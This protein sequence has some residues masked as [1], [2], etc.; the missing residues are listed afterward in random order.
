MEAVELL[1]D[2]AAPRDA[3]DVRRA[4]RDRFDQRRQ[5]AGVL[6]Q[7]EL[8]GHVGRPARAGLIPGDDR[9]L[10]R[11]CGDLRP[12]QAAVRGGT[13]H[14]HQGRPLAGALISDLESARADDLHDRNLHTRA[15]PRARI[16]TTGNAAPLRAFFAFG[17]SRG[18]SEVA[19]AVG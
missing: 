17:T 7:A 8:R 16:Y 14:E 6:G 12:P 11:E 4:E 13:M 3:G 10:V 1:D 15:G 9:K 2:R 18:T 19:N 5:A